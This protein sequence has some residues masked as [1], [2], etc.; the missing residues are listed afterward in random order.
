MT[1]EELEFVIRNETLATARR[2]R[3]ERCVNHYWVQ[4][5]TGIAFPNPHYLQSFES[6]KAE[7]EP[8]VRSR[9]EPVRL[10][11][12]YGDKTKG[13]VNWAREGF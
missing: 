3:H 2:V 6:V 4:T 5:K 10:N 7:I 1:L 9:W 13:K 11:I 12:L 8:L